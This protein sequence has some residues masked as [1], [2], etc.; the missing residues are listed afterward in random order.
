EMG[1]VEHDGPSF[2]K[3]AVGILGPREFELAVA[4]NRVMPFA[5]QPFV[6]H[7]A[8]LLVACQQ[9]EID[10]AGRDRLAALPQGD[11]P[12]T[13]PDNTIPELTSRNWFGKASAA[14]V[15]GFTL[16][17]AL[18]CIFAAL[19]MEGDAY[20][21][22]QGQMAMWLVSPIWCLILSFCFLFRSSA[23]AWGWLAAANLVAWALYAAIRV[24][25]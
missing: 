18:T 2:R 10:P 5:Y 22:P 14:V 6:E 12:V 7:A 1:I 13:C 11:P 20:F 21:S 24:L 25:S 3:E 16:T 17:L 4:D 15:P 19:F 23:R 9:H 8:T